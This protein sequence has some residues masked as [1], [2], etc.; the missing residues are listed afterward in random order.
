MTDVSALAAFVAGV[1]SISSPCVLPLIPVYL[2]HLAG[3]SAGDTSA[4]A[5]ARVL[6]NAGAYVLGFTTVFVMLGIALGAAGSLVSA[7]ELVSGNRGWL[8]RIGGVVMILLGLHQIGLIRL[9]WSSRERRVAV[10]GL[11]SGNLASSFVIGV[12]FGAGWSPCVGPILGG[13]LTMATVSGGVERSAWLLLLYSLGLAIPFMAFAVAFGS[14]QRLA[15]WLN[16]RLTA[17]TSISG[18]ILIAA[19]A[20]MILGIYQQLFARIV[21]VAPWTPWEPRL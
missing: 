3:V 14:A 20:I 8:I 13:I 9:P 17:V 21:E 12:T 19:G 4:R 2:I 1:L 16:Q 7:G 11:E 18:A 10:D 6:A 5:R 15:R